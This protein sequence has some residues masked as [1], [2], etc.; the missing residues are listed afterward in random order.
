LFDDIGYPMVKFQTYLFAILLAIIITEIAMVVARYR[1]EISAARN[2]LDRLGNQVIETACGPVEY[3]RVGNGYPVLVIHGT[4]GGFDAGLMLAKPLIAAD[5]QVI[6]VSRFGFLRSPLPENASIDL[7]VDAYDRLLQALNIPQAIVMTASGGATSAIR[8]AVRYPRRVAAL[9]MISPSAPGKVYVA[10]PPKAAFSLMRSNFFYWTLVTYFRAGAQRMIGV[11]KGFALTS[12]SETEV[13]E[14]L[15]TTLPSRDRIDGTYFDNYLATPEFY[16]EISETSP[17][18]VHKI[19]APVLVINAMDD[20]YSIP[21]NVRALVQKIPDARL[22]VVP[23]GGHV[24]LGRS[25]EV[26]A[27]IIQ[28]LHEK[29]AASSQPQRS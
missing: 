8:Y 29:V 18:S 19:K 20:P 13:N 12:T 5:F 16:A 6:A 26:N 1:S 25:A 9:I 28:F 10:P 23:D 7:Q 14:I 24:L 21:E 3:A 4:F 27:E 11:P 22:Y 17:Y 2:R 15:A